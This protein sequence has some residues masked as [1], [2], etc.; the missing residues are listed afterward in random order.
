MPT[1]IPNVSDKQQ[2]DIERAEDDSAIRL[3]SF[4]LV[5]GQTATEGQTKLIPAYDLQAQSD[6][7]GS[8]NDAVLANNRDQMI[9]GSHN[10]KPYRFEEPGRA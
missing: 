2:S 6:G 8:P 4:S 9:I 7:G 10:D 3:Q 1:Y 5:E